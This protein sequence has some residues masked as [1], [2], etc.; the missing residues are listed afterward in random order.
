MLLGLL[1]F[2]KS[3]NPD[4]S[5]ASYLLLCSGLVIVL[6]ISL[7][8]FWLGSLA[9]SKI[10]TFPGAQ[11]KFIRASSEDLCSQ[12]Q[13]AQAVNKQESPRIFA[14]RLVTMFLLMAD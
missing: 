13:K 8:C 11:M 9:S 3:N 14:V 6:T 1:S 10:L 2:C 4:Y 7:L 12:D 5:K